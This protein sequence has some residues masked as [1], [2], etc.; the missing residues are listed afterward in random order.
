MVTVLSVFV[1]HKI[2]SINYTITEHC[3][4]VLYKA[5]LFTTFII[6]V[7]YIYLPQGLTVLDKFPSS[8]QH[9]L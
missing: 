8:L 1:L 9:I 5:I 4:P 3:V 7:Y 6:I 2:T